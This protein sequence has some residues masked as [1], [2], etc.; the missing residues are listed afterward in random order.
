MGD[1]KSLMRLIFPHA[2][3]M[4]EQLDRT[5]RFFEEFCENNNDKNNFKL[6][7][8]RRRSSSTLARIVVVAAKLKLKE[9]R[10]HS[11][12]FAN[13]RCQMSFVSG[14][15]THTSPS[16]RVER[17]CSAGSSRLQPATPDSDTHSN[18]R[19]AIASRLT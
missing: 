12:L 4:D 11:R 6:D 9:N 15:Q 7:R 1:I 18:Q 10:K 16:S 17:V 2:F 13:R 5:T 8:R 3:A 14:A 19:L